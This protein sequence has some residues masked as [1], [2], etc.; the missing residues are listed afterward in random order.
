MDAAAGQRTGVGIACAVGAFGAFSC[1]D[2]LVKWLSADYA[3][4][5]LVFLQMVF[6]A[7]V[8]SV[9][10]AATSGLRSVVPRYPALVFLRGVLLTGSTLCILWA[11]SQIPLADAYALVFAMPI[12][13]T[14]LAWPLLGETVG[15]QRGL[16]IV[17]GFIGI[18]V[19][20]RPGFRTVELAHLAALA[21]ALQFAL[22]IIVLR[23][24][25]VGESGAALLGGVVACHLI[26]TAPLLPSVWR[27]PD[28]IDLGLTALTGLFAALAHVLLVLAF[29]ATP[30]ATVAPFHYTQI[31]WALLF[32]ALV[33][34]DRPDAAML[35][36]ATLV[37]AA[38]VLI[39]RLNPRTP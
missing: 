18:L 37:I 6:A 7:P 34:G 24:M 38:G 39:L 15:W 31:L 12:L 11:I 35:G 4:I 32:G 9:Y 13:A 1:A 10:I 22:S 8:L 28:A 17:L 29:R 36:G 25:P 3:I 33:F 14:V 16:A 2:V 30:T 21:A 5:Q 19:M 27:S 20:L 23:R 26:A